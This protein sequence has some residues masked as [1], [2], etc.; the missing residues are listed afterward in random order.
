MQLN[1][2][3][4]AVGQRSARRWS[5]TLGYRN[6]TSP[7]LQRGGLLFRQVDASLSKPSPMVKVSRSDMRPSD[8]AEIWPDYK[9]KNN[10]TAQEDTD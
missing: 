10:T 6:L 4:K 2:F 1:D 5:N 8:W 9:P 7:N 3:L